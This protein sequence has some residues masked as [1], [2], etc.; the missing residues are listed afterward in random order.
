M[1]PRQGSTLRCKRHSVVER[2]RIEFTMVK[3]AMTIFLE[4]CPVEAADS[5]DL[6]SH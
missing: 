6:Q 3:L 4:T 1:V 2:S 5:R